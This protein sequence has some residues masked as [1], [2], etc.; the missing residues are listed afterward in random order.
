MKKKKLVPKMHADL[1]NDKRVLQVPDLAWMHRMTVALAEI[2]RL[3]G[4]SSAVCEVAR[5]AGLTL[6]VAK[7]VSDPYDWKQ[8]KKAGVR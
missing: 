7:A 3:T 4:A 2:H 8:L 6:R 5:D 1:I